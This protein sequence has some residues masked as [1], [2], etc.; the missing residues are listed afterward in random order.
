MIFLFVI[1]PAIV[2][3]SFDMF[4]CVEVEGEVLLKV[5]T[6][7]IC[8]KEKHLTEIGLIVVPIMIIWVIGLPLAV[9]IILV[10]N[11]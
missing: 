4:A 8:W 5:D 2:N 1:Y 7:I 9:T 10:K 11:R 6:D 3:L